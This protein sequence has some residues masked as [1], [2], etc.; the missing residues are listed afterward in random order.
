MTVPELEHKFAT[1]SEEICHSLRSQIESGK[2]RPGDQIP[3]EFDLVHQYDVSRSTVRQAIAVLEE[4]GYLSRRRRAGTFVRELRQ[5]GQ[6]IMPLKNLGYL[7]IDID[8]DPSRNGWTAH[9][10]RVAAELLSQHNIDLSIWHLATR[11]ILR[12][13]RIP[14]LRTKM[15]QAVILDGCVTDAHCELF[16]QHQIPY[17]ALGNRRLSEDYPRARFDSDRI[18]DHGVDFLLQCRPDHPVVMLVEPFRL[19]LTQEYYLAYSRRM[20]RESQGDPILQTADENVAEVMDRFISKQSRPFS[21][22]T[23][24]WHWQHC[25]MVYQQRELSPEEWPVLMIGTGSALSSNA[26]SRCNILDLDGRRLM[27]RVIPALLENYEQGTVGQMQI[28]FDVGKVQTCEQ[29][30]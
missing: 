27:E 16:Q 14:A 26:R 21:L 7:M 8:D 5:N 29:I 17:L 15:C 28:N 24:D 4:E 3:T 19:H 20:Q 23:T 1:R 25:Y 12:D 22:I 2:Y 6:P 30:S 13:G 9:T 11:D 10:T 18:I